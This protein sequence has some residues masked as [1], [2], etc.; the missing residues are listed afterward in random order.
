MPKLEI[1]DVLKRAVFQFGVPSLV[2]VVQNQG[3][4]IQE[5]LSRYTFFSINV[6]MNVLRNGK[7]SS[8]LIQS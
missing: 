6:V 2:H 4:E 7:R 3:V 1:L 8:I 5:L